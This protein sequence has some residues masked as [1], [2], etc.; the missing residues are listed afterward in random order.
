VL[1]AQAP[2]PTCANASSPRASADRT[3][4]AGTGTSSRTTSRW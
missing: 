4:A 1:G 2:C 3:R